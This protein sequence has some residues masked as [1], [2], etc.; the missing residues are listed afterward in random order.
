M[1]LALGSVLA[2]S[3]LAP[4]DARLVKHTLAICNANRRVR[5]ACC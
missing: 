3:L 4:S 1:L 2:I 5:L